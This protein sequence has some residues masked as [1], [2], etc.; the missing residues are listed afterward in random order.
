[1]RV[2]AEGKKSFRKPGEERR[3]PAERGSY[4]ASMYDVVHR[5]WGIYLSPSIHFAGKSILCKFRV[6]LDTPPP[7]FLTT[8][9][10]I[11]MEAPLV[12]YLAAADPPT[13]VATTEEEE[14]EEGPSSSPTTSEGT[15][16][17]P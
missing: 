16:G 1:M 11:W 10:H 15:L 13:L 6:F 3:R 17:I 2:I 9:R 4:W 5:I 8:R 14:E 12:L 7:S